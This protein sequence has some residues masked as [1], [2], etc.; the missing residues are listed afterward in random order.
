MSPQLKSNISSWTSR[1]IKT[2]FSFN[3]IFFISKNE[4]S[5]NVE[6]FL[7]LFCYLFYKK[8]LVPQVPEAPLSA[9]PQFSNTL[10]SGIISMSETVLVQFVRFL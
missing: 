6:V 2:Y 3:V 1:T 7:F 10:V 5:N 8:I 4:I 9:D